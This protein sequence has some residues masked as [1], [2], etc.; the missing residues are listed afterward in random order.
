MKND[1]S[2]LRYDIGQGISYAFSGCFSPLI[3]THVVIYSQARPWKGTERRGF[4]QKGGGCSEG[5]VMRFLVADT[6]LYTLP[7]RSVGPS[8]SPSRNIFEFWVVFALMLLPNR[9]RLYRRVS[10]LVFS[11]VLSQGL[12]MSEAGLSRLTLGKATSRRWC[13]FRTSLILLSRAKKTSPHELCNRSKSGSQ[14]TCLA[15][16]EK[17]NYT[18]EWEW[19]NFF[20]Y[21]SRIGWNI[22]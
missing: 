5:R 4:R 13:K 19:E 16:N 10:G 9:P 2:R 11:R 1:I 21:V 18:W 7:C 8:V 17:A 15:E 6:R 20:K 3:I 22:Y 12:F 14:I